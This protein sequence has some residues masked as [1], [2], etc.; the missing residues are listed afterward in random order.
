MDYKK[1][2]IKD[3]KSL[4]GKYSLY[5][6]WCDFLEMAS[7]S[8]QNSCMKTEWQKREDKYLQIAK[9]YSKD[10]LMVFSKILGKIV[11][12]MENEFTDLL[13]EIYMEL[14][15]YNSENGQFFTP[16]N[17]SQLCSKVVIDEDKIKKHI[18]ENG[19]V[20][21]NEPS[22][23]G[24]GMIIATIERMLELGYNPQ[25]Q[26]FVT[27]NDLDI[28]G[29]QMTYIMLSLYGIPAIVYHMNTLSLETFGEYHTPGYCMNYLRFRR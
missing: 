11:L 15:L 27:A 12:C 8:I 17:L 24:G 13:G 6:I 22:V 1:D 3:F 21:I 9:K 4:Q 28:K 29:A 25:Q 5:E 2:I 18:E 20:T 16:Y 7:I 23:G 19:Y 26:L 10:D 14:E